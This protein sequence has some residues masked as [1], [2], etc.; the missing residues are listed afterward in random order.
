MIDRSVCVP[1]PKAS[2]ISIPAPPQMM[3]AR[4]ILKLNPKDSF[5]AN[6][7]EKRMETI[8]K[9]ATSP[10]MGPAIN[11]V[12]N[13]VRV[14]RR[15]SAKFIKGS[16]SKTCFVNQDAE[17]L[18][19]AIG[20]TALSEKCLKIASCAKIT[21]AIGAPNPAE[22]APATPHPIKMSRFIEPPPNFLMALPI[23]APK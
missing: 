3:T 7:L 17:M 2:G 12:G 13:K 16:K 5:E 10:K 21:P 8:N 18:A 20:A 19:T 4:K 1:S 6:L 11:A 15:T 22:I 23:V 9:T 14:S